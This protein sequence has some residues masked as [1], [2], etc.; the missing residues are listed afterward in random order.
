MTLSGPDPRRFTSGILPIGRL[1]HLVL[2]ATDHQNSRTHWERYVHE[3]RYT[4][5][6]EGEFRLF[7]LVAWQLGPNP[8][9][10][11]KV[12]LTE[13]TKWAEARTEQILLAQAGLESQLKS[14]GCRLMWTKG[15]ALSQLV[16]PHP[17]VR[18]SSDLDAI[19]SWDDLPALS[20]L[21]TKHAWQI[22]LG[23]GVIAKNQRYSGNEVSWALPSGVELDV[24]WMPRQTF[25]YDPFLV[26]TTLKQARKQP[27][28][29]SYADPSWLLIEAI[30][31]G[32]SANLVS[33]I[34]WVVD[35]VWLVDKLGAQIDW[36]LVFEVGKRYRTT[37]M[38][39]F[40]LTIIARFTPNIPDAVLEAMERNKSHPLEVDEIHARAEVVDL[41]EAYRAARRYNLVLRAPHSIYRRS[42]PSPLTNDP[43]QTLRLRLA[44]AAKNLYSR[45][46][47]PLHRLMPS[48]RRGLDRSEQAG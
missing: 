36:D 25:A 39:H 14:Q 27:E 43:G 40:G 20:E 42:I 33:P 12:W 8:E 15:T 32:L 5:P 37:A 23:N 11:A 17:A 28:F 45:L 24:C 7:P 9:V 31:H 38:L 3:T 44:I 19:C 41:G 22:K 21:A 6:N 48:M 47:W 16:Y 29:T 2:A 10:S 1:E 13:N 34:R 4:F 30:D 46:I 35:A 26:E 18:P